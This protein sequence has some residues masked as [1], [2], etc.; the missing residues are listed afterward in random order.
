MSIHPYQDLCFVFV[1]TLFRSLSL[2][3]GDWRNSLLKIKHDDKIA[4][5]NIEMGRSFLLLLNHTCC[6]YVSFYTCIYNAI[7]GDTVFSTGWQ[8]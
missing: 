6:G 7:D 2:R 4:I 3:Y 5:K 1:M 8:G